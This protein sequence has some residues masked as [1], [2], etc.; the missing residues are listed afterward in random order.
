MRSY[1]KS[2][3]A[4]SNENGIALPLVLMI[5]IILVLFGTAAY[6]ASQ[7]SLLQSTNLE[8]NLEC[9]YLA[10]SAVDATKEAWTARWVADPSTVPTNETFYNKY[11][12]TSGSFE[13]ATPEE[14]G[15]DHV[16]KT[17][18]VYNSGTG[19]C[20]ITSTAKIG[21]HSATVKAV[22]EK[23]TDTVVTGI[24]SDSWYEKNTY[25]T[26]IKILGVEY[27]FPPWSKWSILPGPV[28]KTVY[29]DKGL[30]Y[31]AT[32]HESEGTIS[33]GTNATNT[34]VLFAN[35]TLQ[36][37]IQNKTGNTLLGFA[38]NTLQTL[39]ALTKLVFNPQGLV[40]LLQEDNAPINY[41]VTGL[42]AKRID[43]KSP[44]N[45]Y[46]NSSVFPDYIPDWIRLGLKLIGLGDFGFI[47]NP[48][49]L[50]LSAETIVFD[51]DLTIGDSSFGNLTLA[52]PPGGGIPGDEV[53]R[54]VAKQNTI[55]KAANNPND[56]VVD[57]K[58]IDKDA[59]YGIIHFGGSVKTELRTLGQNDP[60]LLKD[61]TFYF[62]TLDNQTLSVGTEETTFTLLYDRFGSFFQLGDLVEDTTFQ[63]LLDK[64]YFIR[65]SND[66]LDRDG[67][68]VFHYE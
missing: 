65:A 1:F 3:S 16:I 53:Y 35:G 25:Q 24:G 8:K 68:V 36:Q 38:E 22:S 26:M 14:Y 45:L 19:I 49:S 7:S 28:N 37:Y 31:D 2:K 55:R 48:H 63:T 43:F 29:D 34:E 39:F 20:T 64:G 33:I 17:E 30:R 40:Q 41:S 12:E 10:R 18:Q 54:A 46:Y 62:R 23:L 13:P 61:K 58:L 21:K 47:P 56:P 44:V 5:M 50:I 11:D 32:Y 42:Q 52:L 6:T 9:R 15:N 27:L 67:T 57:L 4:L 66:T 59:K 51:K 60:S